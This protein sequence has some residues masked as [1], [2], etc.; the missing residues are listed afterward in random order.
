MKRTILD[1]E[2]KKYIVDIQLA[3]VVECLGATIT[4]Q[5]VL[6]SK[7]VRSKRIIITYDEQQ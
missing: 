5:T 6:D 3:N 4:R 7:G 2:S 1:K